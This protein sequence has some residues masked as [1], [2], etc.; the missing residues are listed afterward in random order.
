MA[1]ISI[2]SC[3][4]DSLDFVHA[5]GQTSATG[6]GR[7]TL[8]G[9]IAVPFADSTVHVEDVAAIALIDG[10]RKRK[11]NNERTETEIKL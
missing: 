11:R 3:T 9:R 2:A 10:K 1:C 6:L 7:V 5:E 4:D 8:A